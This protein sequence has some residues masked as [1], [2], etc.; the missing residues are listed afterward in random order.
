MNMP[1]TSCTKALVSSQKAESFFF[2]LL[3]FA[4]TLPVLLFQSF[5][6]VDGPAHLYNAR[7]IVDLLSNPASP[8]SAFLMFNSQLNPN[9][10]GHVILGSLMVFFPALLAE[11]IFLLSY[12]IFFPLTFR[13]LFDVLRLK[14]QY[15][16]YFVFPFTYSFLFYYGFYNFNIG[17]VFLFL[18]LALWIR[19]LRM[20]FTFRRMAILGIL[21]LFVFFSHLFVFAIL[22]LAV[23]II[24]LK[25]VLPLLST[26]IADKKRILISWLQQI[27]ILMPGIVLTVVYFA[28]HPAGSGNSQYLS[29]NELLM[30]IKQVQPAKGI[31]YGKEDIFS[32]WIFVLF[33]LISGF[34]LAKFLIRP[35]KVVMVDSVVWGSL[36]A[37]TL[38]LFMVM[39]NMIK[40]S[41]GFVSSRLLVFFFLFLIVFLASLRTPIWL[42]IIAFAIINYV[43]IALINVYVTAAQRLNNVAEQVTKTSEIIEP[44]STVYPIYHSE[45][46][47]F[48]HISNYLG[49]D[50]PLVITDNI[51][52]SLNYFP[53]VWKRSQMP[54]LHLGNPKSRHEILPSHNPNQKQQIDYVFLF[55]DETSYES[56]ISMMEA[57][58]FL[59][60]YYYKI[61]EGDNKQ[62]RL[63]KRKGYLGKH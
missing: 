51:E 37:V 44:Y 48:T 4:N 35:R 45:E 20:G 52:A 5:P 1:G 41:I 8:L 15:L 53:L 47:I 49:I 6:T 11:K 36:V 23:A 50:K 2:Y 63:Y 9:L 28:T 62:V 18:S 43:N 57:H 13:Y 21:S 25:E 38:L 59:S 61:F 54:H 12:L 46:W 31:D 29:I 39:P 16:V 60:Q 34:H 3:L 42:K 32:K 40:G 24:N 17:L 30:M 22:L 55:L 26:T 58:P 14:G 10:I 7:L 56:E 27:F 33:A 19:Y